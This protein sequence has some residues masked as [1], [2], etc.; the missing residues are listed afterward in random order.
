M[1]PS[2]VLKGRVLSEISAQMNRFDDE[3]TRYQKMLA[4]AYEKSKATET[5]YEETLEAIKELESKGL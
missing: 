2:E 1:K 5:E 3:V 4:T